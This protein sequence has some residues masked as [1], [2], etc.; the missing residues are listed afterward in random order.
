[1]RHDVTGGEPAPSDGIAVYVLANWEFHRFLVV[2]AGVDA[3]T[4]ATVHRE[5]TITPLILMVRSAG[6]FQEE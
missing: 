1:M 4:R 6:A 2:T 5:T 3:S